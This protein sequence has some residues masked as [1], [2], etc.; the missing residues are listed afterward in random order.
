M[1]IGIY[2]IHVCTEV[3]L[4]GQKDLIIQSIFSKDGSKVMTVIA[5]PGQVRIEQVLQDC[6]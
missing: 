5:S 4:L 6:H 2:D 1:K 3:V